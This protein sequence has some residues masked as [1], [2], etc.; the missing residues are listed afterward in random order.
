MGF[1]DCQ[2]FTKHTPNADHEKPTVTRA[3]FWGK[4]GVLN[5]S[6]T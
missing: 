5:I 2:D 4:P 3:E 6:M 1:S